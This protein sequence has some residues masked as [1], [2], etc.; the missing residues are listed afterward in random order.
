MSSPSLVQEAE[1]STASTAPTTKKPG[2][3][4]KKNKKNKLIRPRGKRGGVKNRKS[5]SSTSTKVVKAAG[6]AAKKQQPTVKDGKVKKDGVADRPEHAL[7]IAR[8]HTL[9]KELARTT[10][11]DRREAILKE[12]QELGGIDGYQN[13]SIFGGDKQRGGESGKWCAL[14][15]EELRGK[16]E[17]LKLLDVGA[18]S[19]TAYQA[20]PW[21]QPTSIDINP[22]SDN[23]VKYDFMEY[24]RPKQE[25]DKSD[26]VCLSLVLNF[27]GDLNLRGQMLIHAHNYLK[28][29][30]LLY[31]VL[32]A[33][34]VTNSRYLNHQRL[35][36]I[37]NSCGWNVLLS[38]DSKRLTRW[39][40]QRKEEVKGSKKT[41]KEGPR[42]DGTIWKKEEIKVSATANNFCIKVGQ[43]S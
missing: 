35:T 18:L 19:G 15:L 39:L 1:P 11:E 28:E 37:L 8:Y 22:R 42:W 12:Q 20:F 2:D 7:R 32:P 24:P 29:D 17:P 38:Q 30:G 23:V 25:E 14:Q 10:D 21:I 40:L 31:L 16:E 43:P 5:T 9:E 27:I 4:P 34:C 36:D 33:P 6:D 41:K 13:D 3:A 26:L